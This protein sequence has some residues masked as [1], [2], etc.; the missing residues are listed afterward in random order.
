VALTILSNESLADYLP[1]EFSG[2]FSAFFH[3][4][5][6]TARSFSETLA[7][8]MMLKYV[9]LFVGLYTSGL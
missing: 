2:D 7:A 1:N 6:E 9:V 4:F 8:F 3:V 5:G